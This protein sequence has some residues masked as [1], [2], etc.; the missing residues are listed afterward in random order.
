MV[1][2]KATAW[3]L[4]GSIDGGD[5]RKAALWIFVEQ[6]AGRECSVAFRQTGY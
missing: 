4:F 6:A 3:E 2:D 1:A 5:D